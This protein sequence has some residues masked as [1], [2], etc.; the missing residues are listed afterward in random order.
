[1]R[2]ILEYLFDG[3]PKAFGIG[4]GGPLHITSGKTDLVFQQGQGLEYARLLFPAAATA[5]TGSRV[6]PADSDVG[7]VWRRCQDFAKAGG[8]VLDLGI[9]LVGAERRVGSQEGAVKEE[10][11]LYFLH[12]FENGRRGQIAELRIDAVVVESMADD[13]L[14]GGILIV[15]GLDVGGEL[16]VYSQKS[17]AW[18]T[19]GDG[20]DVE[21]GNGIRDWLWWTNMGI[22]FLAQLQR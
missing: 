7:E 1:M 12:F 20:D 8:A 13:E 21:C 15:V 16:R 9:H 17:R 5:T 22:D 19:V 3:Y 6:D 18:W 2:R 10:D 4:S 14:P 11:K